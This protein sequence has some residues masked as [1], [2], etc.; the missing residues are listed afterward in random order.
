MRTR[1]EISKELNQLQNLLERLTMDIGKDYIKIE[2]DN[3]R[4]S[5]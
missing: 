3:L 1:N 5:D 2:N 4:I